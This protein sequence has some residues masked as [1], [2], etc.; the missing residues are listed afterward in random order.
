MAWLHFW[1]I[2][3]I[4]IRLKKYNVIIWSFLVVCPYKLFLNNDWD[5]KDYGINFSADFFQSNWLKSPLV[6]I[7]RN[8]L[9]QKAKSLETLHLELQECMPVVLC[10]LDAILCTCFQIKRT[11]TLIALLVFIKDNSYTHKNVHCLMGEWTILISKI[12]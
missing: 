7:T 1:V 5:N 3:F 12:S 4:K 10:T 6:S 9:K 2:F 11:L 8:C